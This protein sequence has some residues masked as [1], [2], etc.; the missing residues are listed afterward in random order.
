MSG[1]ASPDPRRGQARE[2]AAD[3]GLFAGPGF[4]RRWAPRASH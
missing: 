4:A 3:T 2:L 1:G